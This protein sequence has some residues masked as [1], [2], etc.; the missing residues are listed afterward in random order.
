MS[1]N[2]LTAKLRVKLS[3]VLW[4]TGIWMLVAVLESLYIHTL[5]IDFVPFQTNEYYDFEELLKIQ[6]ITA[7]LAGFIL[8]SLL[9]FFLRGRFR[10]RSF[11]EAVFLNTAILTI[12]LF[13][14]V[15]IGIFV[16]EGKTHIFAF[17]NSN[18]SDQFLHFYSS[19]F[20]L[21]T[22]IFWLIII[23]LTN[24]LL[25]VNEKYGAGVLRQLIM[26]KYHHPREEERIF[27]FLD[28]K[29]STSIA[30]E[31]GHIQFFELLNDFFKDITDPILFT[32]GSI[33]QYI[34]DEV[35]IVWKI[36]VGVKNINCIRCFYNIQAAINRKAEAYKATYGLVP[37]FKAAIHCGKVTIGEI[38]VLKR[39]IVFSGDVLNTTSRMQSMC[40]DFG[41][42]LLISKRL[43]D[44]IGLPP[45]QME[46]RKIGNISL[47]GKTKKVVLYTIEEEQTRV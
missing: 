26:G 19:P 6:V 18:A 38:G 8:G 20:F 25:D 7:T 12:I 37:D 9:I 15:S 17:L 46:T 43:L 30:E 41:V 21:K 35:I 36:P 11:L 24:L 28:M 13:V 34:G 29:G 31:I 45:N 5:A 27:M 16:Y 47:K 42:K 22:L 40:N 4:I 10:D 1:M 33:Y 44:K 23:F 3:K 39:D 32:S 2:F 14:A